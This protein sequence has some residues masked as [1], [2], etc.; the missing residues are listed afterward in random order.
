[1]DNKESITRVYIVYF[2]VLVVS[3]LVIVQIFYLQFYKGSELVSQAEKQVFELREIKA[4]RGNIFA[5]NEQKTSLSLSVPRYKVHVDFKVI[6]SV[7]FYKNIDALSDSLSTLLSH[8]SLKDWKKLLVYQ[9][10]SGNQYFFIAD[11]LK[12]HQISR[13]KK[14]PIFKLGQYKGGCIIERN[15]ERVRPYGSLAKRTIGYVREGKVPIVGL[16][17]AFNQDLKG[18]DGRMLMEKIRGGNWKPIQNELSV[19]PIP[20]SDIYTSIDINI[21]DVANA[22]LLH[23]LKEQKAEKGCVVLM[24]VKTGFVK[25]IVNLTIDTATE[26]YSEQLNHAV[27]LASEPGS[28]FK[29][30]SL[31]VALEDDKLKISDSINMTG[32]YRFYDQT[33]TDGGKILG[34]NTVQYAFEKSSN[35]ISKL[36]Y[37]NYKDNPQQF[38]DGLKK[39]GIQNKLGLK[40]NGEGSPLIRDANDPLFSGVSLP[41]M[42]IGYEV[43]IT[44]LQTLAFYNAVANDGVLV[45]PQFVKSIKRGDKILKVFDSYVLNPSICSKETLDDLTIMLKGVVH[46]GTARNIRARG[47]EIAGKTGTSKIAQGSKGYGD[48]YQ[49]SFCGFFPADDPLYSCIVVIQG[50]TKDIYGAK[51]SGTVFKEIADKVY[52]QE[53]E[54]K[55][56]EIQVDQFNYPPSKDGSK[57]D[58]LIASKQMGIQIEGNPENLGDCI[59]IKS[60]QNSVKISAINYE[61]NLVPNVYGMGLNDALYL[62]EDMHLVVK[63]EGSGS[64]ISQSLKAGS[65]FKPD[66][67]IIKLKLG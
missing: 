35:V 40:I 64:V 60:G 21:Q 36:I 23:Q 18:Q 4:P 48:K 14:F 12:S 27:G 67:T 20:G 5:E 3:V 33:L 30:A 59:K 32:R 55:Q 11:R 57:E 6:D 34:K 52:A 22:A 38:V 1:M 13:L 17:G 37:D 16:E 61:K 53:F 58:F 39:I 66:Q 46:R 31:L 56:N 51:V 49:A 45:R 41:W 54:K 15:H 25:A 2:L 29:L 65:K 62:L 43:E 63:F 26:T 19:E 24:D 47:F 9:K 44:P 42:S 8:K 28:T 10:N 50:P 7:L